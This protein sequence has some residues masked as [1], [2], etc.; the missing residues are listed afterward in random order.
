MIWHVAAFGSLMMALVQ[1][2]YSAV[3][4]ISDSNDMNSR[5]VRVITGYMYHLTLSC[6]AW[7]T[8]MALYPS[9]LGAPLIQLFPGIWCIVAQS[10]SGG[11]MVVTLH[12]SFHTAY[13]QPG[14]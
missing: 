11:R 3:Q 10:F 14:V 4:G 5:W 12:C 8:I 7:L 2:L 1:F 9:L 6:I 13:H